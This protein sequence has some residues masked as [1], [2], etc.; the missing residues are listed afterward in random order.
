MPIFVHSTTVAILV[1]V[2]P[3]E[4][5]FVVLRLLLYQARVHG[6][7]LPATVDIYKQ[8]LGE[9]DSQVKTL[10]PVLYASILF[11]YTIINYVPEMASMN[12]YTSEFSARWFNRFFVGTLPLSLVFRIFDW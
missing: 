8:W 10:F 11:R 4:S 12:I 5:A 9:F 7:F 6:Q 3:A 1:R 2:L